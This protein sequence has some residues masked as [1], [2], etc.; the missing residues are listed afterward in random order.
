M[1]GKMF[2][3]RD[4]SKKSSKKVHFSD[5]YRPVKLVSKLDIYEKSETK[6]GGDANPMDVHSHSL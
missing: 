2:S 1:F 4:I 6:D 3:I 5:K